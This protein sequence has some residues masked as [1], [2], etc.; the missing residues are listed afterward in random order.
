MPLIFVAM[1]TLVAAPLSRPARA[2]AA[3]P[4]LSSPKA[5]ARSLFTAVSAGDRDGIRAALYADN[6]AQA[7]LADAMADFITANKRLG[8]V[9]K[10]RYGKA[11]DPLGRG[12]LDPSDLSRLD[13]AAVKRSGDAATVQVPGQPRPMTFR[14]QGEQW[15]LVITDF[16]GAQPQNIVRQTRLVARMAEAVDE[17]AQEI[18]SGKYPT[19]DAAAVAIQSKL[20]G[21]LLAF[22]HP[23]T[24]RAATTRAATQPTTTPAR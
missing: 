4:D 20:H 16:G 1:V 12:M 22:A 24:T 10:A 17:S 19:P 18:E 3:A 6:G 15:K 9:A 11:G 8:D 23:A 2:A 13:A 14:R 5:A 21:V 7:E